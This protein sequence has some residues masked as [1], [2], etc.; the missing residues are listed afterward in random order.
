M[1]F[2]AIDATIQTDT[3]TGNDANLWY[4]Q[5]PPKFRGNHWYAYGGELRFTLSSTEGDF[6]ELNDAPNT[7]WLAILDCATCNRNAGVRLAWPQSAS[8]AFDGTTASFVIPLHETAGWL[9]DPKNT[10]LPWQP[11]T[12]CAFVEVLSKLT[13]VSIL[14]DFTRFY[15][16]VALDAIS[17]YHGAGQPLACY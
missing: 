4:F 15:E 17:F 7:A 12:Q 14:G 2:S 5:A 9:T 1:L 3:V 13:G 10:L 11:P 6:S 8:P 16:T